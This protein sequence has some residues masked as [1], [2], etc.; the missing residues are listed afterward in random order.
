MAA[1][2]SGARLLEVSPNG[3]AVAYNTCCNNDAILVANLDGSGAEII[4]PEKLDGYGA[5]VDR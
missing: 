1:D 4:T 3:E 5:D 2:L